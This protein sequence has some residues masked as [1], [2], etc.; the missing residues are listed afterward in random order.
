MKC[1]RIF[2]NLGVTD[3]WNE[4]GDIGVSVSTAEQGKAQHLTKCFTLSLGIL[5]YNAGN[6]N[7]LLY[8]P[9]NFNYLEIPL[10]CILI[11]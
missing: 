1:D 7:P 5:I 8:G 9:Y 11:V 3:G 6:F 10:R 4:R 2:C